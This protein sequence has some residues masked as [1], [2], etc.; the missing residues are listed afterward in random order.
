[1]GDDSKATGWGSVAIGCSTEA[2]YEYYSGWYLGEE[3]EYRAPI[4]GVAIGHGG[5]TNGGVA[6]G[7]SSYSQSGVA[8]GPTARTLPRE[9]YDDNVSHGIAIGEEAVVNGSGIAIGQNSEVSQSTYSPTEVLFG[10]TVHKGMAIGNNA[11]AGEYG[12]AIGP[13]TL[14][15]QGLALGRRVTATT[16]SI[17]IGSDIDL[18]GHDGGENVIN[19]GQS[20]TTCAP[21]SNSI[22]LGSKF[23]DHTTEENNWYTPENTFAVWK[24]PMLNRLTGKIPEE[25]LPSRLQSYY[26]NYNSQTIYDNFI[27]DEKIL[28]YT[29]PEATNYLLIEP[30]GQGVYSC[31]IKKDE[32]KLLFGEEN[33]ATYYGELFFDGFNLYGVYDAS[34]NRHG[35]NSIL[36]L[37]PLQGYTPPT[38]NMDDEINWD[39]ALPTLTFTAPSD[40][41]QCNKS[42]CLFYAEESSKFIF[43]SEMNFV[44]GVTFNDNSSFRIIGTDD[45]GTII[46]NTVVDTTSDS[47]NIKN[48]RIFNIL[49]GGASSYPTRLYI[50][51]NVSSTEIQYQNL[52]NEFYPTYSRLYY[53][54]SSSSSTSGFGFITAET[55]SSSGSYVRN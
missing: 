4:G 36:K 40:I 48:R 37:T 19:I 39:M 55:G 27:F 18:V 2:H 20:G 54:T 7:G 11:K 29:L 1:M 9:S 35:I 30:L 21:A 42:N 43:L 6:I 44:D 32:T 13:Y 3:V 8:I 23:I 12:L 52:F 28:L 38:N 46:I 16:D 10:E 34:A 31:I 24:Y 25:R 33:N 50:F 22:S 51:S 47:L 45:N 5:K 14:S 26:C 17:C 53:S 15:N 41:S 49:L